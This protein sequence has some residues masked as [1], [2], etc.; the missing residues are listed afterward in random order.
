MVQLALLVSTSDLTS[1]PLLKG[2][3]GTL[4]LI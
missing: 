3:I 2:G 4:P 1:D